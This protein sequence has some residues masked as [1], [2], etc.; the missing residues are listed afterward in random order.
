MLAVCKMLEKIITREDMLA[1]ALGAC[2][3]SLIAAMYAGTTTLFGD[4]GQGNLYVEALK[5]FGHAATYTIPITAAAGYVLSKVAW[6][7]TRVK[8][9]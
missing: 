6:F 8:D 1:S 3:G 4:C 9:D 7:M 2:A 5:S